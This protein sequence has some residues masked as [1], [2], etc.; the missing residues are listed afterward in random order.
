[1][2][3]R[4]IPRKTLSDALESTPPAIERAK[5]VLKEGEKLILYRQKLI[6]IADRSEFN[7]ATV[8]E[9]EDDELA[10]NSDD[11]K[12][13]LKSEI[14]ANRIMKADKIR[15]R[16]ICLGGIGGLGTN[17]LSLQ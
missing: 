8:Q 10:E 5:E 1:M 15:G 14:R 17:L 16:K 7:W 4:G 6:R 13:L 12:R 9:Y 11:K 2:P 3:Q